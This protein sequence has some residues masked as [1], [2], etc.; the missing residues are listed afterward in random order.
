MELPAEARTG[1]PVLEGLRQGP[2]LTP[3][4]LPLQ[5]SP[6]VYPGDPGMEP[7]RR[8]SGSGRLTD[9]GACTPTAGG[10]VGACF[11]PHQ[12]KSL[13]GARGSEY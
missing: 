4:I 2:R 6:P 10:L 12:P 5:S 13:G 11:L 8:C 9:G 3:P 1:G 7:G